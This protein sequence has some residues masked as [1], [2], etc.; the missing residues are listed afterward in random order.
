[1]PKRKFSTERLYKVFRVIVIIVSAILGFVSLG[2]YLNY[3][4]FDKDKEL[5]R[6]EQGRSEIFPS[7][8]APE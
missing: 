7:V 2:Y 3:L 4:D 5:Q 6:E 8:Q 1:M